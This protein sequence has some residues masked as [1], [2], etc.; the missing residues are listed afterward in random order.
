MNAP[1]AVLAR[2]LSR[3]FGDFVAV[4]AL[5]LDIARGEVM[6]FLGPNGAGKSTTMR[7]LCGL[8]SPS[9]GSATVAG[10]DVAAQAQQVREHIGYMSQRFSLYADLTVRENLRF[11]A[12]I[13][14]VPR[15]EQ[16]ARIE[17]A[18]SMAD[19]RG[20]GD[21]RVEHLAGGWKQRLALGCAIL[22]RPPVLFLDEPTSGVEPAARRRFWDLIHDLAGE[23]VTVLVSTHYMDEA[24]YC[25]RI[26][27]IDRGRLVACGSP[28]ELR[29]RGL[30][31]QL[32]SLGCDAP[33]RA[34]QLLRGAPGVLDASMFGDRLHLLLDAA[35]PGME[36]LLGR[37][38]AAGLGAE[39]P[40]RIEPS[41]E[42]VFVRLVA[43]RG[44]P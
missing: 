14:R 6:G 21:D 28:G 32:W 44:A 39:A 38:A 3:R 10:F 19:L 7:L 33:A 8:L 17:A 25:H 12:G 37:L 16:A 34:V 23:G 42:D 22:H 18:L 30:G 1:A 29:A 9:G 24:E 41:L 36:P 20:H 4:D 2:G 11:F 40:R 31:G 35:G 13:Y 27:L 5:D 15:A 26:A 43:R